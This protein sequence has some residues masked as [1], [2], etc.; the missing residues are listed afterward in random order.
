MLNGSFKIHIRHNDR[1]ITSVQ[2]SD[3]STVEALKEKVYYALS[4]KDIIVSESEIFR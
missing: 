1:Y 4:A 3:L 2:M